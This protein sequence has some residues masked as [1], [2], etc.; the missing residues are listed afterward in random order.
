MVS[1]NSSQIPIRVFSV[2]TLP[3]LMA[4]CRASVGVGTLLEGD[5]SSTVWPCRSIPRAFSIQPEGK[6]SHG[7]IEEAIEPRPGVKNLRLRVLVQEQLDNRFFSSNIAWVN[8]SR[9]RLSS[10]SVEA[11]ASSKS[12]RDCS[13][14]SP[15]TTESA[16]GVMPF[17]SA[18]SSFAPLSSKKWTTRG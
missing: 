16:R 15:A 13:D 17:L 5:L 9:P 12:F 4:L 18:S 8:G 6:V 7:E 10:T 3:N 14:E 11:P 1:S 2:W